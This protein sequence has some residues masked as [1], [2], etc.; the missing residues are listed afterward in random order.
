MSVPAGPEVPMHEP[1]IARLG[2]RVA[3]G[4]MRGSLDMPRQDVADGAARPH[5][6]IERVDRRAGHAEGALD[7]FLLEHENGRVDRA[8]P[9]HGKAPIDLF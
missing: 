8:H 9:G 1:D 3:F 2:A 7:P 4:H 5:R 6:R